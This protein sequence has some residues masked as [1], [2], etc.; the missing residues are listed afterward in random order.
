MVNKIVDSYYDMVVEGV[1]KERNISIEEVE[2]GFN[3][4]LQTAVAKVAIVIGSTE[5]D[6]EPHILY[7]DLSAF[8]GSLE[9]KDIDEFNT[10]LQDKAKG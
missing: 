3:E 4:E 9:Q 6:D 7:V 1:A 8:N 5:S 2:K 10:L